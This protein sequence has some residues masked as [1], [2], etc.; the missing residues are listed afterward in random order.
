MKLNFMVLVDGCVAVWNNA[1]GEDTIDA[2]IVPGQIVG[3]FELFG[4][5]SQNFELHSLAE[6]LM[7]KA[8]ERVVKVL[9][10]TDKS[11]FYQRLCKTLIEKLSLQNTLS[12]CRTGHV[13]KRLAKLLDNFA[14]DTGWRYLTDLKNEHQ[15]NFEV[16][17]YFTRDILLGLLSTELR[18][19][20]PN[21]NELVKSNVLRIKLFDHTFV[22]LRNAQHQEFSKNRFPDSRYF[23]IE[24]V[25]HDS[26]LNIIEGVKN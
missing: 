14:T 15:K 21:L 25:N 18:S 9:L 7:L 22:F 19:L 8:S 6:S 23:R 5:D 13:D 16:T 12:K 3:E 17:L 10:E 24:V 26:L 4:F 20:G 1:F 11:L 2:L